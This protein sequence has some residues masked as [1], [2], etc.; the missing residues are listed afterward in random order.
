MGR[1]EQLVVEGRRRLRRRGGF[2]TRLRRVVGA[3]ERKL[4]RWVRHPEGIGRS[5]QLSRRSPRLLGRRLRGR[6]RHVL[7]LGRR[8]R[9]SEVR[10]VLVGVQIR[11][12]LGHRHRRRRGRFGLVSVR[13]QRVAEDAAR[14]GGARALEPILTHGLAG[15]VAEVAV[16]AAALA[17]EVEL[18][19]RRARRRLVEHAPQQALRRIGVPVAPL[20]RLR[21]GVLAHHPLEGHQQICQGL[22]GQ[23]GLMLLSRGLLVVVHGTQARL[24]EAGGSAEKRSGRRSWR[25]RVK[26][27]GR[28]GQSADVVELVLQIQRAQQRLRHREGDAFSGVSAR[29]LHVPRSAADGAL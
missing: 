3:A 11:V 15:V 6:S 7:R 27:R 24:G 17:H 2:R 19:H 10:E 23:H 8:A 5:R 1:L 26:L 13:Q 12:H 16:Q 4:Q 28:S 18:A 20:Q 14:A 21:S 29:R 22:R 9:A 25:L